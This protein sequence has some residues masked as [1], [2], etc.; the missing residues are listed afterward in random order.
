MEDSTQ[1]MGR[2]KRGFCDTDPEVGVECNK[3]INDRSGLSITGIHIVSRL[4][5]EE[6]TITGW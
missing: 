5:L 6:K 1:G 3:D 2:P 4:A